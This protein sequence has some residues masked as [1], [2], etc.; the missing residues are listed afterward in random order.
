MTLA[1]LRPALAAL[2]LSALLGAQPSAP[3]PPKAPSAP[4]VPAVP[5]PPP[6]PEPDAV[7]CKDFR[8]KLFVVQHRSAHQLRD[9]LKAL[10]S[11][12]KGSVIEATERDGMKT[13]TVRDFP[14]NLATIESALKRLDVPTTARKEVELHIHVLFAS[15]HEGASTGLP[16][17]LKD[18][19]QS[20]RA[21]L[22]YRSFT[23]ATTF[24]QRITSGAWNASGRGQ[25]ELPAETSKGD[26]GNAQFQFDWRIGTLRVEA[27]PEGSDAL[28]FEKFSLSAMEHRGDKLET[29]AQVGSD[30]TLKTGEK[31]VVGTTTLKE[32]GLIVVLTAKVLP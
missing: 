5:P 24:V 14:E 8:S 23:P 18:V 15:K 16:E 25:S 12:A 21:T 28:V 32:K 31:V 6:P 20:L 7:V 4:A 2:S 17:E 22:S 11:G 3:P 10:T 30:L 27:I 29:L 13:L 9:A 19:L 1:F 26:K